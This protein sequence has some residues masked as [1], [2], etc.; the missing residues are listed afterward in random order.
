M[1]IASLSK[2][3]VRGS[4]LLCRWGGE[5]FAILLKRCELE[6]AYKVAEQLRLN[7]QNHPFSFDDRE[8]SVTI[9]LGVA[10]LTENETLDELF[11]RVD[12]AVYLAKSE[13]RN[14]AEISYYV[15]V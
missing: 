3:S 15:S 4:D 10:E 2:R 13:G 9:S 5:Q 6:Q 12:E 1:D 7:V 8:A 14:R 11:G